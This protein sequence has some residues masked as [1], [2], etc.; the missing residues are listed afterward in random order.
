MSSTHFHNIDKLNANNYFIWKTM[1]QM[2]LIDK[3]LWEV[4]NGES[5]E[6]LPL[7]NTASQ[8]DI[9]TKDQEIKEWKRKEEKARATIV[10]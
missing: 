9:A 6:P 2:V 10:L 8:H 7:G 3:E 5:Q 1:M 4:V